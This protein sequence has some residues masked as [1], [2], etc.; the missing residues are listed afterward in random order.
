MKIFSHDK[1]V[2]VIKDFLSQNKGQFGIKTELANA[3]GCKLSYLSHVLSETAHFTMDHAYGAAR[4]MKLSPPEQEF[5]L[6]LVQDARASSQSYRAHLSDQINRAKA[7][8]LKVEK[9][10]DSTQSLSSAEY[11][12][13]ASDWLLQAVHIYLTIPKFQQ[14]DVL[15]E[16]LNL[17]P[18]QLRDILSCLQRMKLVSRDKK[19]NHWRPII[20]DMH[21]PLLS[22]A[23]IQR[24]TQWKMRAIYDMQRK[25]RDSV[26]Y[27]ATFSLSKSDFNRLKS[28]LL[29][30]LSSSRDMAIHSPEEIVSHLDVSFFDVQ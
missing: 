13:Y 4:F 3:A 17:S 5:F 1:Y 2:E 10:I 7:E 14:F 18:D 24:H 25:N 30:L 28:D 26:H 12:I 9:I 29:S 8:N 15:R 22:P 16:K 6:L 21:A 11:E 20:R 23:S 27:S 19:A